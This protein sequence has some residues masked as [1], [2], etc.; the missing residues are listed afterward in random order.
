MTQASS[1]ASSPSC[2]CSGTTLLSPVALRQI[3]PR[4]SGFNSFLKVQ[5]TLVTASFSS[6]R[7]PLACLF[8]RGSSFGAVGL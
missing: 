4:L 3:C 1:L 2:F 8:R 7:L 6:L 5:R